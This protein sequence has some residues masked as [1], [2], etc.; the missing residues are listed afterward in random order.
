MRSSFKLT[1]NLFALLTVKVCER[2]ANI[3]KVVFGYGYQN[4][5]A[6][7]KIID[8]TK[9]YVSVFRVFRFF[10]GSNL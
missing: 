6:A 2:L 7:T 5:P 8:T 9:Q 4:E 10:R 1:G 3:R